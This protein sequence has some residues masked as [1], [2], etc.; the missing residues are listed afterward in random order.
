VA[1]NNY[2][3]SGGGNFPGL[4]GTKTVYASPDANR[5]VLIQYIKNAAN[6]TRATNGS[7]RSW[8]FTKV[9]T[10]GNVVFSSGV[11]VLAQATAGGVAGV[12]LVA[13]DDGSGKNLSKYKIDLNQ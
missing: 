7:A 12:T 5:D 4:D 10:A 2:R 9:V 8:H 1:T 3:A 13:A 6:V 11:G